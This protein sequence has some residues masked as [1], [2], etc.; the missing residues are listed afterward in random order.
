MAKWWMPLAAL[1]CVGTG[2]ALWY[3]QD[4]AARARYFAIEVGLP[5]TAFFLAGLAG[6]SGELK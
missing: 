1:A 3:A 6:F 2:L 4:D 5:H